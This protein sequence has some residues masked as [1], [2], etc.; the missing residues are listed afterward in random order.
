MAFHFSLQPLLRLRKSYERLARQRLEVITHQLAQLQ[1]QSA[2][3]RKA[4]AAAAETLAA[5]MEN[6]LTGAE[7]QFAVDCSLVREKRQVALTEQM[8]AVAQQ[9]QSQMVAFRRAQQNRQIVENLRNRQ[10]ETYELIQARRDQQQ[11]D[12]LFLLRLQSKQ[13]G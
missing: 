13:S 11:L 4:Q 1:E 10:L 9:R 7:L 6:G 3:L 5:R 8:A 2:A 12:D